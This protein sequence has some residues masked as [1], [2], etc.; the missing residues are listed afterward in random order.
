[1]VNNKIVHIVGLTGGIGSGKSTIA[2]ALR[3]MGY[4][5]YDTDSEAKRLIA[6]DP[7]I[8]QAL[9]SLLGDACYDAE[10]R[11]QTAYVASR[12]FQNSEL[13]S[14]L[15][16]IVHP[17]VRRDFEQW[18]NNLSPFPSP[19]GE[20]GRGCPLFIESAIL[21]ESGFD[22]LCDRIVLITAPE[23][24]R[25]ARV[26]NRDHTDI[27]KVRARIRAQMND[28]FRSQ[29]ADLIVVNDGSQTIEQLCQYITLHL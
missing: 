15:N 23:D 18:K 6:S 22:S 4:P 8:K 13:L 14:A 28:T 24:I 27:N 16:S 26:V 29:H 2:S 19:C 21:F 3:Q 12:V 20:V 25:L 9:I 10:G 1:M 17:A 7:T 5:V 11:Y